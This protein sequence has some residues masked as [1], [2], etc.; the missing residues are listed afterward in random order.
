MVSLE[1]SQVVE[2]SVMLGFGLG[3]LIG[4]IIKD[5]FTR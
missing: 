5:I 4:Y 3:L 1:V 2:L